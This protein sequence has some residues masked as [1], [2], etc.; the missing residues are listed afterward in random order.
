MDL[1]LGRIVRRR[2]S[3]A[4]GLAEARVPARRRCLALGSILRR[5]V[6]QPHPQPARC[7]R[8][9]CLVRHDQLDVRVGLAPVRALLVPDDQAGRP[10]DE[11][12]QIQTLVLLVGQLP[13]EPVLEELGQRRLLMQAGHHGLGEHHPG[14]HR[15]PAVVL[16]FDLEREL[17]LLLHAVLGLVLLER[18]HVHAHRPARELGARREVLLTACCT[19][20]HTSYFVLLLLC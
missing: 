17:E 4:R 8:L 2:L 11:A 6:L 9:A 19:D 7:Q 18:S 14:L 13:A 20:N 10:P 15:V 12:L 3:T 5:P 1:D 16:Q